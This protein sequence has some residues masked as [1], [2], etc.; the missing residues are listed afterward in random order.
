M[1]TLLIN[2]EL[3]IATNASRRMVT[4]ARNAI[5][6]TNIGDSTVVVSENNKHIFEFDGDFLY[7]QATNPVLVN[8]IQL[9]LYETI[10]EFNTTFFQW[11][12]S[13]NGKKWRVEISFVQLIEE[14]GE[15]YTEELTN[16][17]NVRL[18]TS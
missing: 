18:I 10:L 2:T 15:F 9:G 3:G 7:I 11:A 12:G 6:I 17:T 5:P 8:I 1:P 13:T 14:P 16:E 4:T